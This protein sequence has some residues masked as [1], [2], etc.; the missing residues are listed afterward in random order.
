VY[1]NYWFTGDNTLLGLYGGLNAEIFSYILFDASLDYKFIFYGSFNQNGY[2]LGFALY[3]K[4]PFQMN[5]KLA[6]YPLAGF[7]F[8]MMFFSKDSDDGSERDRDWWKDQDSL[9]LRIGGGLNYDFSEHLRFNAKLLYNIFLYSEYASGYS[10]Y[11]KHGP[12]LS[13]GVSYVF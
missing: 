3:G 10:E 7:G 8:D 2:G 11:S 6:L 5:Q 9:Y 1:G 12:G 4:Y 13:L